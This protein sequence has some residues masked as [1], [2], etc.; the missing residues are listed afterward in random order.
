MKP[1]LEG[2]VREEPVSAKCCTDKTVE[3]AACKLGLTPEEYCN[4]M[5][6]RLGCSEIT[7]DQIS[8]I[9]K[10]N[11]ETTDTTTGESPAQA[12][13]KAITAECLACQAR[14]TEEEFCTIKPKTF[15]CPDKNADK[16]PAKAEEN[17]ECC[18]EVTAE[19]LACQTGMTAQDYC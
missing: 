6:D 18:H 3:C 7:V 4:K 10:Q 5:P 15:G 8:D 11:A 13:C 1:D 12:C 19:C 9:L 14:V 17:T 16:K 2:C